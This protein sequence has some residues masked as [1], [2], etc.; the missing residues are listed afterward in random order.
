MKDLTQNNARNYGIDLLRMISM[1]MVVILHV[2][3]AGNVL[4]STTAAM[5]AFHIA[6]AMEIACYCAVNSFALITGYVGITQKPKYANLIQMTLQV[7]LYSVA[8]T[9]LIGILYP[10]T[11]SPLDYVLAF[12]PFKHWYFT[13]YFCLFFFIPYIN[14]CILSLSQKQQIILVTTASILFTVLPIVTRTDIADT[15]AGYSVIWLAYMYLLGAVLRLWN[16]TEKIKKIP[17]LLIYVGSV[18]IGVLSKECIEYITPMILGTA[19]GGRLLIRYDS[20]VIV[21]AA[22][23]LVLFFAQCNFKGFAQKVI[24]FFSPLAFGVYLIHELPVLK[25]H[26]I[27]N[28]FAFVAAISPFLIPFAVLA[29]ALAI[30]LI[31][32]LIEIPRFYIFKWLKVKQRAQQLCDLIDQ[33]LLS[34]IQ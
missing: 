7:L 5:P 21:L 33:K 29:I 27:R 22:V 1:L 25:E 26:F 24:A 32:T 8:F 12:I 16:A 23:G 6:W 31:C 18:L 15:Q 34:K 9:V 11:V 13:A 3:D 19:R 20:P 17:A 10:G 14:K 2:L 28:K 4:D 30:Y